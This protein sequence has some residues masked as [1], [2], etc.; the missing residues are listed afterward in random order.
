MTG[1]RITS[2]WGS[3]VVSSLSR[4]RTVSRDGAIPASV[5]EKESFNLTPVRGETT[6][7]TGPVTD[8]GILWGTAKGR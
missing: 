5:Y 7:S 6:V 8:P 3:P 4:Y 2:A 1:Q